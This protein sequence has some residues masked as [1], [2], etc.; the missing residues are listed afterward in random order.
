MGMGVMSGVCFVCPALV[1]PAWEQP[2]GRTANLLLCLPPRQS[3]HAALGRL[4]VS[5]FATGIMIMP[6]SPIP[7]QEDTEAQRGTVT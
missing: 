3:H 5:S 7:S 6:P 2:L 4:W 1:I